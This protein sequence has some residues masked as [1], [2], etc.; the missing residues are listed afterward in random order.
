[1]KKR[2]IGTLIDYYRGDNWS[3]I[4]REHPY[5]LYIETEDFCGERIDSRMHIINI[6]EYRKHLQKL[7]EE[8]DSFDRDFGDWAVVEEYV[9]S[10]QDCVFYN[11]TLD[12]FYQRKNYKWR[13]K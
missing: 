2:D 6:P 10:N 9:D 5:E 1:M 4:R 3:H 13:D 12:E 11:C 7:I 8:I